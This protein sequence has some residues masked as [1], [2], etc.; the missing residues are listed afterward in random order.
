M[1]KRRIWLLF[2]LLVNLTTLPACQSRQA[3]PPDV[4]AAYSDLVASLDAEAPGMSALRLEEFARRH[5]RYEIAGQADHDIA[6]WRARLQPAYLRARDLARQ[7]EFDAAE[8][9]LKDV[10]LVS[11]DPAA[12]QAGEFLA[13]EFHKLK[14][15]RLLL[16]GDTEGAAAAATQLLGS[17]GGEDQVAAA[18]QLLDAA[19]M[20]ELGAQMTRTTALQ[21]A[22]RALHVA[23]VSSYVDNGQFPEHLSLDDPA[24]SSL[25]GTG[26]L[27]VIERLDDYRA[28]RDTF[29]VTVVAKGSGQRLRVTHRG[30]EQAPSAARP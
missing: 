3:T 21:S 19:A 24:L 20:A 26:A 9:I 14:A 29:S 22:A 8:S 25:R 28:T 30:I 27:A 16:T 1:P 6:A 11:G 5:A 2:P 13:F 7:G 23:V 4:L 10:A 17:G 15:S 12:R 18:Q